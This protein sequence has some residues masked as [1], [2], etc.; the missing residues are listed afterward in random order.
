LHYA[1]AA[2]TTPTSTISH[3]FA[4][5]SADALRALSH[6]SYRTVEL[7]KCQPDVGI[8]EDERDHRERAPEWAGF[9]E[10]MERTLVAKPAID[11]ACVRQLGR[12][13]RRF[14]DTVLDLLSDAI[15]KDT[16]RSRTWTRPLVQFLGANVGNMTQ[17]RAWVSKWEPLAGKAIDDFCAGLPEGDRA[18]AAARQATR[19]FRQSL[20]L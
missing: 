9:R 10:L 14:N 13:A 12:S 2:T 5:Q 15:L 16:A 20:G 4:F 18:A 3:C 19:D 1:Y 17:L 11:E 7:D 8:G 6:I